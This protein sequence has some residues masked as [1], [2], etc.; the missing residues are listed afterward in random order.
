ME[1]AIASLG[2][3]A[4]RIPLA[5][6]AMVVGAPIREVHFGL[7]GRPTHL[8]VFEVEDDKVLIYAIRHLAQ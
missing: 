1:L 4:E 3:D 8:I 7:S 5:T 6:E 2:A